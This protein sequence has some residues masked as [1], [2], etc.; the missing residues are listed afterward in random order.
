VLDHCGLTGVWWAADAFDAAVEVCA[1]ILERGSAP[2]PTIDRWQ[3]RDFVGVDTASADPAEMTAGRS[4]SRLVAEPGGAAAPRLDQTRR[5]G[6]I[7]SAT[8]GFRDQF[9]GVVPFVAEA[10]PHEPIGSDQAHLVTAGLID[11]LHSRWSTASTRFASRRWQAPVVDLVALERDDP[12]LARWARERL[13]PKVVLATQT[14]VLEPAVDIVGSWWPSVPTIAV[15]PLDN[16]SIDDLWSIA[17]VLASPPVSAWA[18]DR[19]RGSALAR[20]A[21]KLSAS[22]VLEIPLPVD[23]AAWRDGSTHAAAAHRAAE[24]GDGEQWVASLERLGD[25]M[26]AAYCA[27]RSVFEWWCERRPAWR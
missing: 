20:D 10:D 21:I 9:Y 6:S 5:L 25:S 24:R 23:G 7:A 8:A 1:P 4:W 22:Q 19:Y 15:T 13:V 26:T 12:R 16:A 14:R 2:R 3:G 11:P 17:A 27:D 18:L